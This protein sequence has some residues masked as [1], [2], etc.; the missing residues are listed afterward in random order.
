MNRDRKQEYNTMISTNPLAN[1]FDLR[2]DSRLKTRSE[3]N[4]KK[5]RTNVE[6]RESRKRT[7]N[8]RE[9]QPKESCRNAKISKATG[10]RNIGITMAEAEVLRTELAGLSA[11]LETK[12]ESLRNKLKSDNTQMELRIISAISKGNQEVLDKLQTT[13]GTLRKEQ[14]E[15]SKRVH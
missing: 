10:N 7:R 8:K 13:E 3:Q 4:S 2:A 6:A 12:H 1:Q 14:P 11:T 5:V 9:T 15:S